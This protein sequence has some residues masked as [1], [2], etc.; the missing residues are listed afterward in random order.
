MSVIWPGQSTPCAFGSRDSSTYLRVIHRHSSPIGTLTRKIHCQSRPLVSRPP[1]SG[2]IA[3]E[4]PIAAPYAASAPA[5]SRAPGKA[6]ASRASETANMIA[7]PMP[8]TARAELSITMSWA[9]PQATE[10]SVKMARPIVN[11]RRRPRRSA[12]AP[13]VSTTLASASV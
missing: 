6:W 11:R 2:P 13:A 10:A 8:C 5:R 9:S 3:N 4:A 7:A 12:S 1:T